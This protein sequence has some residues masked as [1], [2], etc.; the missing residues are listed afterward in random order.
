L[1]LEAGLKGA[2]AVFL[3]TKFGS[4]G[5]ELISDIDD[6]LLNIDPV[7][8]AE[9]EHANAKTRERE[10]FYD[11]DGGLIIGE[12][13]RKLINLQ[14]M[15]SD[16]IDGILIPKYLS[17]V[18]G[19]NTHTEELQIAV[20]HA[21]QKGVELI[22]VL[23]SSKKSLEAYQEDDI[24]V[25]EDVAKLGRIGLRGGMSKFV[26]PAIDAAPIRNRLEE[27]IGEAGLTLICTGGY[28]GNYTTSDHDR[29]VL[30]E[31]TEGVDIDYIGGSILQAENPLQSMEDHLAAQSAR[32]V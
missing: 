25:H 2:K 16:G 9:V 19:I 5:T 14:A 15:H 23:G 30:I 31:N 20:D 13:L 28:T 21:R 22:G 24:D 27:C 10:K 12:R 7:N 3:D 26:L 18:L 8:V 1:C 29:P 11:N 17:V 6:L 4:D 32:R